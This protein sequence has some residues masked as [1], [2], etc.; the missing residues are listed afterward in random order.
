MTLNAEPA[1]AT[2]GKHAATKAFV[3]S[4]SEKDRTR[5][6]LSSVINDQDNDFNDNRLIS[7]NALTIIN[8]LTSDNELMQKDI[9]MIKL[10]IGFLLELLQHLKKILKLLSMT[11]HS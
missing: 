1:K 5:W 3:D 4:L 10:E 11:V 6:D 8:S 2:S 7:N 9:M